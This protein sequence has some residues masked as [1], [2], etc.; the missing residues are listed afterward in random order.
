MYK[1]LTDFLSCL[2]ACMVWYTHTLTSSSHHKPRL[3]FS[4][5]TNL[6]LQHDCH[7]KP[8]DHRPLRPNWS[9]SRRRHAS[10]HS[11]SLT[12]SNVSC[13]I[14][15]QT[16]PWLTHAVPN[17]QRHDPLL[18]P[19]LPHRAHHPHHPINLLPPLAHRSNPLLP[20]PPHPYPCHPEIP[21]HS[22]RPA[23]QHQH[24]LIILASSGARSW[25]MRHLEEEGRKSAVR[26]SGLIS[27][28][29]V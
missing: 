5:G 11:S 24:H 19:P 23:L 26:T 10:K 27:L 22:R 13:F 18:L 15:T 12:T 20:R 29:G 25:G 28:C 21:S 16:Q 17:I 1:L 7:E 2:L 9:R 8:D 4:P 3:T 14:P 6:S